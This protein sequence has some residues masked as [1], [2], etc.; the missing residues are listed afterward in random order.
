MTVRHESI[1]DMLR[2]MLTP[3]LQGARLG[4][5]VAGGTLA[6]SLV[7]AIGVMALGG[8]ASAADA[9]SEGY[10]LAAGEATYELSGS[11]PTV[12]QTATGQALAGQTA[13]KNPLP[14]HEIDPTLLNTVR[15]ARIRVLNGVPFQ[16]SIEGG[17]AEGTPPPEDALE[18]GRTTS[19]PPPEEP[20]P[21]AVAAV[22]APATQPAPPPVPAAPPLVVDGDPLREI[23]AGYFPEQ[24]DRAYAVVMCESSGNARAVSLGGRYFG[25]WQFDLAT[26]QSVGGVG[27][28]SE[29]SVEEQMMRARMLYDARGWSPWGCAW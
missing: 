3:F 28:P 29:A 10:V 1:P 27:L 16:L 12:A 15:Q 2:E 17:S 11:A 22:P 4:A 24:V 13:R 6:G 14:A 23:I 7:I 20:A 9:T 18:A 19:E 26:W 8:G 25:M 21:A 5:W